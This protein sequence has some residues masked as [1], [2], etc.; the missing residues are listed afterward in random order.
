MT[1]NIYV[2]FHHFCSDGSGGKYAAWK[3]FGDEAEYLGVNY[4]QPMPNIPDNCDV[5]I[6]DFSY[7][8][9]ELRTLLNRSK[10]LVVLDHHKTA[11]EA[12]EGEPYAIF[13]MNRS[14]AVIAWEY[15]HPGVPVPTLLQMIQDRDLWVWKM[16]KS[17][18]FL[19][20]LE[21]YGHDVET[22]DQIAE[23]G[24]ETYEAG[25]V[26]EAYKQSILDYS[27]SLDNDRLVIKTWKDTG[28]KVAICNTTVLQSDVGAAMYSKFDVDFSL[29]YF[30]DKDGV[31]RLSF[32]SD[33]SRKEPC[34]VSAIA[35]EFSGGGHR[36]SAGGRTNLKGLG[37]ILG[38]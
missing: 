30:I 15:F 22:W 32:R 9:A 35:K 21:V 31:V 38:N 2:L 6:I 17:K 33:N 37:E 4:G 13:D 26:I 27:V 3:K 5:Y 16:P 29:S 8:R 25:K 18:V 24:P 1:K 36:C 14:G 11:K 10:S 23:P 12:L 19:N 28:L 34:D 20:Y 7:P